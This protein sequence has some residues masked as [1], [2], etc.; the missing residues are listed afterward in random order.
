MEANSA[1]LWLFLVTGTTIIVA[2]PMTA[3]SA[4][5]KNNQHTIGLQVQ[6]LRL[7]QVETL[8]AKVPCFRSQQFKLTL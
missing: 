8:A 1:F 6:L 2:V 7:S 4:A 3:C 5:P